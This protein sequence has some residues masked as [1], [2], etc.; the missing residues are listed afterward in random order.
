MRSHQFFYIIADYFGATLYKNIAIAVNI[1]FGNHNATA[2][3]SE[4]V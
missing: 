4:S 3:E 1:I 2:G